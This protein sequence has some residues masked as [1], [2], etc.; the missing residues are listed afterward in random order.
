MGEPRQ[1]ERGDTGTAG[2]RESRAVS[3]KGEGDLK[4]CDKNLDTLCFGGYM[5]EF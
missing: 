2:P 1:A 5:I 3:W 4:D